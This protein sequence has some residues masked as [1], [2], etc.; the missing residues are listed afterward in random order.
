M[1]KTPSFTVIIPT[2]NGANTVAHTL[3]SLLAQSYPHFRAIVL[4]SGS[5]DNTLQ[6]LNSFADQ[7]ITVMSSNKDLTI[8]QNWRRILDLELEEYI[9]FLGHDDIL[10]PTF[11]QEIIGLIEAKPGASLYQT[12]FDLID[13]Q[14][15]VIRPCR[16]IPY[17][18]TGEQYLDSIHSFKR[19]SYATGYVTRSSLYKQ[20]GGIPLLTDLM[21]ADHLLWYR[22]SELSYKV[23]SPNTAFAY[24]L[25][26]QS[27]SHVTK[28]EALYNASV[29]YLRELELS[30]YDQVTKNRRRAFTF[31]S[32]T[33]NGMVHK[34]LFAL[35]AS[36][37]RQSLDAF[38]TTRQR[39]I[40]RAN[41]DRLIPVYDLP[42]RVYDTVCRL[43]L[44]GLRK[45]LIL[46]FG[47]IR[48]FRAARREAKANLNHVQH[49]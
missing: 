23:C 18:E 32:K 29:G 10:Y 15:R 4:E 43:P 49:N 30:S 33:F 9:T 3:H 34:R 17:F 38:A 2:R 26:N 41:E 48:E 22:L 39:L 37:D 27:L 20:I 7:R 28:L 21:Y 12:H 5:Q 36:P 47:K 24:R 13:S 42:S 40:A 16:P 31:V 46:F 45:P 1:N 25:H 6:I 35:M 19:D 11:L 44:N 8:T 14:E